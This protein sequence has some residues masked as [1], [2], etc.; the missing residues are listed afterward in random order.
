LI[1]YPF[2]SVIIPVFNNG[3]NIRACVESVLS[4]QNDYPDYEVIIIDN[5]STDDT[6]KIVNEYPDVTLLFEHTYKG[7][8]Y[9]ARNRGIESAHGEILVFL[10]STC[11]ACDS[12]LDK[13]IA[14]MV[15]SLAD[16]AG[17]DIKFSFPKKPKA[18][19]IYESLVTIRVRES[20]EKRGT[21]LGGNLFVR[22]KVFEEIGAFPEGIR[23]GGDVLWTGNATSKG[24]RLI[25]CKEAVVYI[26]PRPLL[27]LSRKIWRLAKA[28]QDRNT[29]KINGHPIY[30]IA[31]SI[32][33]GLIPPK[34][35]RLD[36]LL[37]ERYNEKYPV[38]K[39]NLWFVMYYLGIVK[40]LGFS[41]SILT[42]T[43][44]RKK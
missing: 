13:G 9:S 22:K 8:P 25:F 19:H 38:K 16:L 18:Y 11:V 40:S 44:T 21:M 6:V 28:R 12:W 3:A 26:K 30:I 31:K 39:L 42:N 1:K 32:I 34:M 24:Y 2:V 17:G 7:S 37:R 5:G 33:A 41:S 20:I 27:E 15:D 14:C 23:S 29:E 43:L 4:Q 35:S 10:D 36:N